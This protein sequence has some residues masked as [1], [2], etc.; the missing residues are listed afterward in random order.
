[1]LRRNLHG[2]AQVDI[3]EIDKQI[4]QLKRQRQTNRISQDEFQ[5]EVQVQLEKKRRV[6]QKLQEKLR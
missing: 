2:A 5:E 6:M 4:F 3:M 1:V